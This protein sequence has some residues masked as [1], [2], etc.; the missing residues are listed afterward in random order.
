M[1]ISG[2]NNSCN[3]KTRWYSYA[4][5][6]VVEK[7]LR[8]LFKRVTLPTIKDL[9]SMLDNLASRSTAKMWVDFLVKTVLISLMYIRAEP[10]GD[11]PLHLKAV[12]LMMPYFFAAGYQLSRYGLYYLRSME[13]QPDFALEKFIKGEHVMRHIP[14]M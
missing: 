3:V 13:S 5:H 2:K 8:S 10:K 7:L 1:D 11:W 12:K 6:L 9:K 14:G 4:L